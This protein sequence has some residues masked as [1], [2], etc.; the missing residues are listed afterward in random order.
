MV[1][2]RSDSGQV[3]PIVAIACLL[4]LLGLSAVVIDVGAWYTA[5]RH[6]QSVA[7]AAALAAAQDLPDDPSAAAADARS[8]AAA[9]GGGLDGAPV[10]SSTSGAD[11]T[12]AVRAKEPAAII[13]ARVL[14]ITAATVHARA[15]AQVSGASTVDG[16]GVPLTGITPGGGG[17]SGGGGTGDG[18]GSGSGGAGSPFDG[19]PIPL[20]VGRSAVPPACGCDFG[21]VVTLA[22]GPDS[23]DVPGQFGSLDFA[24]DGNA[25]PDDIANWLEDGYPGQLET[26][27]YAGVPGNKLQSGP[28]DTAMTDLAARHPIVLLPVASTLTG[29]GGTGVYSVIG[30]AAFKVGSW[31][32]SG[33]VQTLTGQFV[34]VDTP[35]RGAPAPYFG[36]G[37]LRLTK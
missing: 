32:A 8:Y 36:A 19:R 29:N 21:Q 35:V 27:S 14:G 31:D 9:N 7:D 5:S 13:F 15:V 18:S 12:I 17:L 22:Y 6:A 26:G 33:D 20:V 25:T 28:V 34:R 16:S 11:D 1:R 2:P 4:G 24:N 30:W 23:S 37:R 10:V 3:L